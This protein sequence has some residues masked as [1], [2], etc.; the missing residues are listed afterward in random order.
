[1][2]IG[3]A[4]KVL[5]PQ[6]N[7]TL[8]RHTEGEGEGDGLLCM[9]LPQ[10]PLLFSA[11]NFSIPLSIFLSFY[12]FTGYTSPLHRLYYLYH[13]A[14]SSHTQAQV[15]YLCTIHTSTWTLSLCTLCT[16]FLVDINTDTINAHCNICIISVYTPL[17][18]NMFFPM[19]IVFLLW[20]V[21][22]CLWVKLSV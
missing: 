8:Q 13:F 10:S 7:T 1:M 9:S 19:C 11:L 15:L 5:C 3:Q 16:T 14:L 6:G 20:F 4:E 2:L 12:S 18:V 21:Y 17:P 22:V